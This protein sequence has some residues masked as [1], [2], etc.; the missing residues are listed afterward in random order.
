M[1]NNGIINRLRPKDFETIFEETF[2]EEPKSDKSELSDELTNLMKN[3]ENWIISLSEFDE[4]EDCDI[5]N[6]KENPYLISQRGNFKLKDIS[7]I[8]KY[9]YFS[10]T[11]FLVLEI[12]RLS[13]N[14]LS[15]GCFDLSGK[16]DNDIND[17]EKEFTNCFI[18]L[19]GDETQAVGF[20]YKNLANKVLLRDIPEPVDGKY[21]IPESGSMTKGVQ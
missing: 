5:F 6:C 11:I 17:S 14:F 16:A 8:K 21:F 20:I 9:A 2:F 3:A 4:E 19:S 10:H 13:L 18:L 15:T 12:E 1:E 7:Q